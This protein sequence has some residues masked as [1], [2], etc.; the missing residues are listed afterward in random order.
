[1]TLGPDDV[2]IGRPGKWG[3]PFAMKTEEDRQFVID[4]FIAW[5]AT[6]G[7]PYTL[8]DIRRELKGKRLFCWCHPKP[9]HGHILAL[10]ADTDM[11]Y[12]I[13][14]SGPKNKAQWLVNNAKGVIV[15]AAT[16]S[17]DSIPVVVMNNGPFEAAGIAYNQ[18]ELA[19]FTSPH[20]YRPK[21][22]VM[23][24]RDEVLKLNPSVESRLSW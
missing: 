7:A 8:E 11:G 1:M 13:E 19:A 12:Y 4:Q 2:Y 18:D 15:P 23:V 21:T 14:T 9:C 22:I 20:D 6:G 24:P 5:L 3:N 16:P 17:A 10:L